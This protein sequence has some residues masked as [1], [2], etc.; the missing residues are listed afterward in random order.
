MLIVFICYS[1]HFVARLYFIHIIH[2]RRHRRCVHNTQYIYFVFHSFV[3]R[4]SIYFGCFHWNTWTIFP[5][6]HECVRVVRCSCVFISFSTF[7]ILQSNKMSKFEIFICV[8]ILVWMWWI[9][10]KIQKQQEKRIKNGKEVWN[11]TNNRH[12]L[13]GLEMMKKKRKK[14]RLSNDNNV[15]V[16][17][18]RS[19]CF[20]KNRII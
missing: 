9:E 17:R 2:C 10:D 15:R 5:L 13:I 18:M 19:R 6:V 16:Y 12:K 20:W 11:N 4:L 1:E 8:L 14:I 7:Q 3:A